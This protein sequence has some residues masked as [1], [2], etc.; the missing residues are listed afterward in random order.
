MQISDGD[1]LHEIS[2]PIF[3]EKIRTIIHLSSAESVQR[4]I[5]VKMAVKL[6]KS[7]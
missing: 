5:K 6:L 2:N 7:I 3:W 4:V 1:D